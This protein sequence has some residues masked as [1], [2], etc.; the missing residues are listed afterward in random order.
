[1]FALL[2]PE[3]ALNQLVSTTVFAYSFGYMGMIL[4]PV[5][6]CFVVTNEYFKTR[7]FRTYP[8]LAGPV[9]SVLVTAFALSGLFY[10][11]L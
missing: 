7:L 8:Y 6:I 3:P 9:L 11:L 1:V 10:V 2:G 5:H 4:S